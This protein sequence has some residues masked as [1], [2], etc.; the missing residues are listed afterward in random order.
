MNNQLVS[1]LSIVKTFALSG[2]TASVICVA[3][4]AQAVV[5]NIQGTNY[6][7]TIVE[8][9]YNSLKTQLEATPWWR[10]DWLFATGVASLVGT[11]LG[12]P[13]WGDSRDLQYDTLGRPF[14]D[15]RGRLKRVTDSVVHLYSC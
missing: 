5:F 2:F 14:F 1:P 11:S 9:S 4:P 8:G 7:I 3:S 12:T 10:D 13:N 6:D 15:L